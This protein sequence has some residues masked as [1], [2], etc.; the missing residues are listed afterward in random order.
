MKNLNYLLAFTI[1]HL[2]LSSELKAHS[3]WLWQNP[4]PKGSI[5]NDVC[6]SDI[7]N[8]IAVG[9]SGRIVRTSNGGI[10]WTDE[11]YGTTNSLNS[12]GLTHAGTAVTIS[13]G[14]TILGPVAGTEGIAN[15]PWIV[16]PKQSLLQQNFPN[17]FTENTSISG[18]LPGKAHVDIKVYDF[19]GR[20]VKTL[21]DCEQAIGLHSIKFDASGL[22]AGIY[23]Y[24]LRA[25]GIIETKKMITSR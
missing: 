18:Q 23:F 10:T 7:A 4:V 12:V 11:L 15:K 25:N 1:L 5:L 19:T 3:G 16:S 14:R 2:T 24:Q 22:P 13:E 8:G 9:Y 21:M 20:E 17:P 6:F